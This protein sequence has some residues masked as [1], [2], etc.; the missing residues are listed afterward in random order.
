MAGE[1]PAR[2][3]LDRLREY[4][5]NPEYSECYVGSRGNVTYLLVNK[6]LRR[7]YLLFYR[8]VIGKQETPWLG[9]GL[10]GV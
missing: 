1:M 5:P 9:S 6:T 10:E 3:Q 7:V 4:M 2:W 8:E